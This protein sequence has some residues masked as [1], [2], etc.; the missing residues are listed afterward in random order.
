MTN[1]FSVWQNAWKDGY[2]EPLKIT[3]PEDWSVEYHGMPGD[4]WPALTAEQLREKICHPI[5]S[6]PIR[7][8]ARKGCQAVI[9][10]DDMSRGT[11]C[12]EIAHIVLEE[13]LAGGMDK[14]K[15][16][17]ICALGSHAALTRA[18]F[19]RK[20]GDDIVSEYPVLNHNCFHS[21]TQIGVNSHGVP[22]LINK[23]VMGCDVRIGIGSVTPHPMN[24]YGGGGKLLVPGV[25]HIDTIY[26][27][28]TRGEFAKPGTI[29]PAPGFRKEIEEM[30]AMVGQFFKIDTV[31]NAGLDIIDLYAGDYIDT[32]YAAAKV[33]SVANSMEKGSDK[34]VVVVNANGKYN[35]STIAV[36]LACSMLKPGG[37]VV[38]IN[39]CPCGQVVHYS[40]SAFG[41]N[42]GGRQWRPNSEKPPM[43]CGRLIYYTPWPEWFTYNM[44]SQPEKVSAARTW[45]EVL[46]LLSGHGAGTTAAV[47]SDGSISY[48]PADLR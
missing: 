20:L 10:F 34:D 19:V 47:L 45:D 15:I 24:G 38:L 26:S 37:D 4:S 14:K 43:K 32:Y 1:Q 36:R 2:D 3:L 8:L 5:N 7:E 30:A 13:L 41:L 33:S 42:N 25:T 48:F 31:L 11:P 39:H 9:L 35:E 16:R 21:C 28:H 17:F 40:I 18:D 22:V 44:F 12:R 46:Q 6:E 29:Q 23:E 27:F